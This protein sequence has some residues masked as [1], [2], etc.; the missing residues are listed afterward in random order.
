MPRTMRGVL[1]ACREVVP[2]ATP[3]RLTARAPAKIAAR[4]TARMR[5]RRDMGA[6]P[7]T[8]GRQYGKPGV[9][10]NLSC[11]LREAPRGPR[12]PRLQQLRR[13]LQQLCAIRGPPPSSRRYPRDDRRVPAADS[14]LPDI[15]C[16]IVELE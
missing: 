5:L 8:E 1:A 11:R 16:R 6:F 14:S 13:G 3:V 12:G 2:D 7:W 15:A 9:C 4:G 10:G